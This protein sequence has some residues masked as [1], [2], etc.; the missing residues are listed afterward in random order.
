VPAAAQARPV[1]A[2]A[3]AELADRL[4]GVPGVFLEP[5]HYTLSVHYRA[6]A[7]ERVAEVVDTVGEVAAHHPELVVLSGRRV[8]E[9]QPDID[10]DKGQA[11]RWLLDRFDPADDTGERRPG[12]LLPIY[13]GDDITDEFALAEIRDEGLGIVVRSDEH[14]DRP[15]AAYAAVSGPPALC[16]FLGRVADLLEH[17]ASTP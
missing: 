17:Q 1:L 9:L 6:V 7:P 2:T 8:A 13:A 16:R 4:G 11:L 10:W 5:K 12:R 14:G 15:T 3:G